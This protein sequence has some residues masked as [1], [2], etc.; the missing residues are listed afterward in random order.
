M[1][2]FLFLVQEI[3]VAFLGYQKEEGFGLEIFFWPLVL[4]LYIKSQAILE[5]SEEKWFDRTV[6]GGGGKS[7]KK[8]SESS[9]VSTR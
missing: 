6:L 5:G 7:T 3:F 9:V 2:G 8:K 1:L 4:F